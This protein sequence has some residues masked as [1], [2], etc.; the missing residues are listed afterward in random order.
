M[1]KYQEIKMFG[2]SIEDMYLEKHR[3]GNTWVEQAKILM[4]DSMR[5]L[6]DSFEPQTE[7]ARQ[8]LNKAKL[9][10]TESVENDQYLFNKPQGKAMS[11]LSDAQ[12]VMQFSVE[13]SVAYIKYALKVL[14]E[15]V[16]VKV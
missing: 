11:V 5:H 13:S 14:N 10:L 1:N 8:L 15:L 7:T 3:A 16:E 4:N 6:N 12:E 2:E 9:W